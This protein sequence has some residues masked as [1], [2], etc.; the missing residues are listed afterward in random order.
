MSRH[1]ARWLRGG[2]LALAATVAA[3]GAGAEI[4][5]IE[6]PVND[7]VFDPVSG[8][9]YASVSSVAGPA[10]NR[11]VEIDPATREI[12]RSVVVGSE[13]NRLAVSDDG[14][15]LY[16]GL[17]GSY[18]ARHVS[19]PDLTPGYRITLAGNPTRPLSHPY[20]AEDIEVQPGHPQVVAI[21]TRTYASAPGSQGVQIYE[22]GVQRPRVVTEYTNEIEFSEDGATLY[23]TNNETSGWELFRIR[24][25]S[26]GAVLTETMRGLLGGFYMSMEVHAGLVWAAWGALVDP[27]G[28]KVLGRF[29]RASPWFASS[30]VFDP[31]NGRVYY[32]HPDRIAVFDRSRFLKLG[33][34]GIPGDQRYVGRLVRWAEDRFVFP[35]Y[36]SA[37]LYFVDT[38]L[39]DA[40]A[41]GVP[42][43]VDNCRVTANADQR[44]SD[45]D[46]L[47]D[48][49][50]AYPEVPEPG[51]AQCLEALESASAARDECL[52]LDALEDLDRDGE[53]GRTDRCPDTPAGEPVDAA[54]CSHRQFCA[55]Q[56]PKACTRADWMNDE[57]G[58]TAG[59]CAKG[60]L[61]RLRTCDPL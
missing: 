8:L 35:V 16:V 52:V 17:D 51:L 7:V 50:E 55:A 26:D 4:H 58:A 47:G 43:E 49:C 33:H 21:A 36:D 57:P 10:G 22:A 20:V 34:V 44:D 9:L 31:T 30:V 37:R 61:G 6:L 40:D 29:E 1:V 46:G 59:D 19:L 11:I 12:R 38:R 27:A 25:Q 32:L 18:D 45:W 48:V 53:S 5:W 15:A 56:S 23:A 2:V 41:D 42:D 54:G 13:P 3:A 39:P 24:V 28:R 14:R 60:R